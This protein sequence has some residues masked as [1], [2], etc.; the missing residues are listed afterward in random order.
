MTRYRSGLASAPVAGFMVM[1]NKHTLRLEDL[2]T[3]EEQNWLNDQVKRGIQWKELHLFVLVMLKLMRF[4]CVA[5]SV[6][7]FC[8]L[9]CL[10]IINMYGELIMEATEQKVNLAV[11]VGFC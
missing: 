10:Q 4:V 9:F 8:S 2:S 1:Y 5:P 6:L 11:F 7:M 3:L